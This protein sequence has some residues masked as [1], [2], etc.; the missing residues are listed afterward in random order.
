MEYENYFNSEKIPERALPELTDYRQLLKEQFKFLNCPED[1]RM[2]AEHL[3]DSLSE[4]GL[5]EQ[6][7][8]DIASDI[9]FRLK[10]WIEVEDLER[11]L[12]QIQELE[13]AGIGARSIC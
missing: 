11:V 12:K 7:L 5:L 3:I 4:E 9:S 8:Q 1:D 2:L 13:P 6:N 10:S